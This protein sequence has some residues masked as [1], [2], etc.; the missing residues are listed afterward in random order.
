MRV[1]EKGSRQSGSTLVTSFCYCFQCGS[2]ASVYGCMCV[3]V[4]A[5]RLVLRPPRQLSKINANVNAEKRQ[6]HKLT[7]RHTHKHSPH[8]R[9][10]AHPYT[11]THTRTHALIKSAFGHMLKMSKSRQHVLCKACCHTP[12][13]HYLPPPT[14]PPMPL[15]VFRYFFISSQRTHTPS[16][17]FS[18]KKG[19]EGR[20][21]FKPLRLV[22]LFFSST[23]RQLPTILAKAFIDFY[24]QRLWHDNGLTKDLGWPSLLPCL[25]LPL[26]ALKSYQT[27]QKV[28]SQRSLVGFVQYFAHFSLIYS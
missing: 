11:H 28:T 10:H 20:K 14:S 4:W 25:P 23:A 2:R 5:W 7:H 1:R 15:L 13:L 27:L 24:G 6:K 12:Y 16:W 22:L 19:Q 18:P 3:C 8:T 17:A 21:T 9:T 26:M